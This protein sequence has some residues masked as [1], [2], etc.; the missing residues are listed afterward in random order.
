MMSV[1]GKM[2]EVLEH[3]TNESR[4][5]WYREKESMETNQKARKAYEALLTVTARIPVTAEYAEFSKGVK[6]LSQQYFGKPYGKEEVN[7]YVT[8]FHDAVI[9]YSLAVNETLKEGLSLKNG[10]LVTQKMWNRTFE[11]I[12][13]NVSINEKGD[14]FVDYSLLDMDPETGVY[15]VVANYYGVSQQ[16]VD[17]PGK[18]IHWAGNRGGP[19]SDV[20]V[21]G[22]DGSLCSDELFPQYVIVTSVLSSVVVVFIIMSFFIYRHF[23]LEAELASMTW[24]IRWEDIV[25]TKKGVKKRSGSRQSLNRSIG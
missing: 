13:G 23:Q 11:G 1:N 10:T 25:S 3:A 6:N 7:T 19:P 20:P 16:F 21:C 12:T 15:E 17:I 8:A 22:F 24:K 9:L 14:R 2:S 5:P 4:R 18:H